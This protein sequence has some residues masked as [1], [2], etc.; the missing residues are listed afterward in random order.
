MLKTDGENAARD[1]MN[2]L[3]RKRKELPTVVETSKPYDSKSD[4][5][6]EGAIRR[7]ESQVR[8]LKIA[9][10]RNLGIVMDVH[11][12]LFDW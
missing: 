6:P 2:E 12:P 11:T 8:T 10:E 7:L 4:G 3:A 1:L 9:T 5:R